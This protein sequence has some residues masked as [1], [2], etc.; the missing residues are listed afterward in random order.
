MHMRE[1]VELEGIPFSWKTNLP[2]EDVRALYEILKADPE[3][4][5]FAGSRLTPD[6]NVG[7][8]FVIKT[9]GKVYPFRDGFCQCSGVFQ[10]LIAIYRRK[11]E[12][13]LIDAREREIR[14]LKEEQ[15]EA[16]IA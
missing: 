5:S 4:Q 16:R 7:F 9:F 14:E 11:L 1:T 10:I 8:G 15:E 12:W 6:S 13:E 3:F 2:D